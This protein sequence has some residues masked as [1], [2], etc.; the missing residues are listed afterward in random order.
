MKVIP[1]SR[2]QYRVVGASIFFLI[3]AA[4]VWA[5]IGCT[6]PLEDYKLTISS[7][8]GGNVTEPGEGTL[9][10][11]K[12]ASVLLD[13]HPDDGYWFVGWTG[14]VGTIRKVGQAQLI[15]IRGEYSITA[16]FAKMQECHLTVTTTDG[17]WVTGP[18]REVYNSGD[19]VK[20]EAH[21]NP[22]FAFVNWT[23]DVGTVDDVNAASI[24]IE[25]KGN[26]SITANFQQEAVVN[27]TDSNLKAA[28][29]AATGI[30]GRDDVYPSDLRKFTS[31]DATQRDIS[32]L[33]GLEYWT[34]LRQ[35]YLSGNQIGD[36]SAVAN[37]TNLR[38]LYI[39]HNQIS[40]I[41]PL[42]NLKSLGELCL[43]D[44]QISDISPLANLKSLRELCLSDNQI[45]DISPLANLKSLGEL[46]LS[47]NQISDISPLVNLSNLTLLNLSN[48][49]IS[50]IEPL[51][52]NQG[53]SRGDK[54]YLYKNPLSYSPLI[55][56]SVGTQIAELEVR[57]VIV[58]Y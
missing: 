51:V 12:G 21:E 2:K 22:S 8:A 33:T 17:G 36:I 42:A 52:D 5:M 46:C 49:Q 6:S 39:S 48:N 53:L 16:E 23:G 55:Y 26:Y 56:N 41:S 31:L 57:D 15:T 34:S 27:I 25:M 19:E 9:F 35:L 28:I 38:E 47:D 54:V 43:S 30:T 10:L 50:D 20:L 1:G 13:V 45:S 14:D 7:T 44:N 32:D 4:L 58:E 11:T 29:I 3:T 18:T 37:L 40:D 24:E